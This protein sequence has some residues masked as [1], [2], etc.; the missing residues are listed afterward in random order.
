MQ[1]V[2]SAIAAVAMFVGF[3][4]SAQALSPAELK[5]VFAK[6]EKTP[7]V[8]KTIKDLC[9]GVSDQRLCAAARQSYIAGLKAYL[10][11]N[12][13][14]TLFD[15]AKQMNKAALCLG[16][17]APNLVKKDQMQLLT[18]IGP[19]YQAYMGLEADGQ[20]SDRVVAED[21]NY[22]QPLL[23]LWVAKGDVRT[24]VEFK[25][26]PTF[27]GNSEQIAEQMIA[28]WRQTYRVNSPCSGL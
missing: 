13:G 5:A 9:A 17:F 18:H 24:G 7:V 3:A 4:T 25:G 2:R 20:I 23:G 19:L 28:H 14:P 8:A 21:T 27:K 16:S 11:A 15:M 1:S 10:V 6:R 26:A 12:D 22:W